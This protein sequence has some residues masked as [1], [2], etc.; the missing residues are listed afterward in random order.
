MNIMAGAAVHLL[1]PVE[2]ETG[3]QLGSGREAGGMTHAFDILVTGAAQS[4]LRGNES[5]RLCSVHFRAG[6]MAVAANLIRQMR[7]VAKACIRGA[8]GAQQT[9]AEKPGEQSATLSEPSCIF[10][11]ILKISQRAKDVHFPEPLISKIKPTVDV[12]INA[13]W[14]QVFHGTALFPARTD[15]KQECAIGCEDLKISQR[16]VHHIQV[17][18]LR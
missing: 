4:L 12:N 11:V 1:F 18:L 5:A 15:K 17:V 14:H 10:W 3:R 13:G 16:V 9:G 8:N 6:Q 2:R 7:L